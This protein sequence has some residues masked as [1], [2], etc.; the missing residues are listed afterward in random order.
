MIYVRFAVPGVRIGCDGYYF[1]CEELDK[2]NMKRA[3]F[4]LFKLLCNG[5]SYEIIDADIKKYNPMIRDNIP[6]N[7]IFYDVDFKYTFDKKYNELNYI[8]SADF[9]TEEEYVERALL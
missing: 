5:L 6:E 9:M 8:I 4:E 2:D 1:S 3:M 7:T